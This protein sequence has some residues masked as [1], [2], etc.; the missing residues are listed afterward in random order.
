MMT[1]SI[2]K[3]ARAE[4]SDPADQL[5]RTVGSKQALLLPLV[6]RT[7]NALSANLVPYVD[8]PNVTALEKVARVLDALTRWKT[9]PSPPTP[10]PS[11]ASWASRRVR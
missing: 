9:V 1:D 7:A 3:P 10:T 5:I 4:R 2:D 6:E 8:D 11:S